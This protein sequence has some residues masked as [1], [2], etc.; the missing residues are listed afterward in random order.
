MIAYLA[1]LTAA[2]V[3]VGMGLLQPSEREA[4]KPPVLI[5]SQVQ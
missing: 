4:Q 2:I 5:D 1:T 3:V